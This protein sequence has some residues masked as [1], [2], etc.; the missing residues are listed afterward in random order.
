MNTVICDIETDGLLPTL[1]RIHSH[2]IKER[3][4][5]KVHSYRPHQARESVE[6]LTSDEIDTI[7]YH[8]GIRFDIPAM[9]KLYPDI[10]V[11]H[12]KVLDTMVMS[13]LVFPK[14]ILYEK[15]CKLKRVPKKLRGSHSLKAWGY[16]MNLLKGDYGEQDNAWDQ[17]S[18]AMQGY[19]EQDVEVT[20]ATYGRI[21]QEADAILEDGKP[22]FGAE[23][24]ALEHDVARIIARQE[25][26]GVY[27]D[28]DKAMELA[29]TL[30][31][32]RAELRD[33]L[34]STFK[35]R[36]RPHGEVF[37]PKRDNAKLGYVK[38]APLQKI[39]LT[40][41]N[42][43]SRAHCYEWLHAMHGW[44]PVTLT[45]T[46]LP[47][48]DEV[49]L[50]ELPWP[51][52]KLLAE[53]FIVIKRIGQVAEG[54]NAWIK[55]Y[56]PETH[57]IHGS[58]NTNGAVTGR[59]SHSFPNLAQVPAN[60]SPYGKECRSCFTVPKDKVMIGC[61]ADGLELR[62][63]AGYMAPFDGGEYISTVLNG[64]KSQGTDMHSVNCR[65]I[66]MDP[67]GSVTINGKDVKGRDVAKTWFYAFI[68]GAGLFKLGTIK[69]KHGKA[70]A[71]QGGKD[72]KAF[73]RGL[74]GLAKLIERVQAKVEKQGFIRGMDGRKLTIRKSHS[75][76]NTLLQSAG[77]IIMKR[78]LVILDNS[79]QEEGLTPGIDYE[80]VLNVHDEMQ[81]E[82]DPFHADSVKAMA[83][84]SI[85]LAGEYYNFRC[86]QI[87]NADVGLNWS[88]TH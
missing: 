69:G 46:G 23:C 80:F 56:N 15:D 64:D 34:Q 53:Y 22:A 13:R 2:V 24:I 59:M 52:A 63:L 57:R 11:P 44:E 58:V 29:K 87:G 41:F 35:P 68:Y 67:K 77:A 19:C 14:E 21:M 49:V 36:Y 20:D 86:P 5:G 55:H 26:H 9:A 12:V 27:F 8:N 50:S 4:T 18:E 79:L 30:T 72:R 82:V 25:R 84:Q 66:G 39:V 1:S 71:T 83:E 3:E 45:D 76:L 7:V 74:P 51:E 81:M 78:A 31:A 28:I 32:R 85:R 17:W 6:H 60:H 75:A 88:E 40:E 61:D 43:G 48:V 54:D 38:D 65:A 62:C 47:R 37:T 42:P 16:R 73:M 33:E 10:P 70:A